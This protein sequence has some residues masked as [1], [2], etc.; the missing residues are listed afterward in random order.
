MLSNP[1]NIG[2]MF[3]TASRCA[4]QSTSLSAATRSF[5]NSTIFKKFSNNY[6]FV[7]FQYSDLWSWENQ[8]LVLPLT[9]R[10][11]QSSFIDYCLFFFHFFEIVLK[12]L[13]ISDKV[14]ENIY[15]IFSQKAFHFSFSNASDSINIPR[16]DLT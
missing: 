10:I 3:C 7:I 14:F 12:V 4:S 8:F 1:L 15:I 16:N 2:K 5:N 11:C 9:D 13:E 6:T